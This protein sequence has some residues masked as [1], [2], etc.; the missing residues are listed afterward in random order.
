MSN[1]PTDREQ[2]TRSTFEEMMELIKED[3]KRLYDVAE[4]AQ[5]ESKNGGK[6]NE[7]HAEKMRVCLEN[8]HKVVTAGVVL[9]EEVAGKGE[10]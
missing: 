6:F 1:V 5:A 7:D 3:A 8:L 10:G 4:V 2:Y 9:A